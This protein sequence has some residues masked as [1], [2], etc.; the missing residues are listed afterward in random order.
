MRFNAHLRE[1]IEAS[2][3]DVGASPEGIE[4]M[5]KKGR[6]YPIFLRDVPLRD[7]IIM[8]QE[9]LAVGGDCAVSWGV[10]GLSADKTDALLLLTERQLEIFAS[11]M[12]FQPF[13]GKKIS[14]EVRDVVDNQK[15]S[16]YSFRAGDKEIEL[17][18]AVM[19]ILNVTPDSF[20]DGG[21][22]DR[23]DAAIERALQMVEEGASIIDVGGESS[24]P[25]S[26]RVSAEEELRR[27]MPV[28]KGIREVSDIP[29][30]VD[31][32]KPEVAE[33]AL[34]A[35]ADIINDIYGLRKDGM[36]ELIAEH[37]A[38]VII[39]HMKGDPD[40]MQ[41]NP[42][43]DDVISEIIAFLDLQAE[44]AIEAGISPESIA[45]DPGI[46]FG[47]TLE[48]NL[49]IIREL[50]AFRSLGFPVLLGASRKSFIGMS[51]DLPVQDRK[52]PSVAV[53][54]M[55]LQRGASI[56][57]VHDVKETFRALRMVKFI[58]IPD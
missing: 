57:R 52:E 53:A 55:G 2:M 21:R 29:L 32:Y 24:R 17:P 7:A 26:P 4:L 10:V 41:K 46:G 27:I 58:E 34:N 9:A 18:F 39:M 51:L 47:K 54:C 50:R 48:H 5:S 30:S 33:K 19:G 16:K 44:K 11:K 31:T 8:K 12:E 45:I 14:E 49:R 1:D 56:F 36:A 6:I 37:G 22:Y 20:S 3:S 35:G 43:Y 28:I 23:P 13:N 15:K 38:G 40:N 42:E 25:G